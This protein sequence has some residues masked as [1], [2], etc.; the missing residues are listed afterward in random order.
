M[1]GQEREALNLIEVYGRIQA[2]A[3]DIRHDEET[4][5]DLMDIADQLRA[6]WIAQQAARAAQPAAD[7]MDAEHWVELWRLR[8][9]VKGPD[10]FETWQDAAT[11]ERIRRVRAE[12]ALKLAAQPAAEPVAQAFFTQDGGFA[13]ES[14]EDRTLKALM[15]NTGSR[16][17]V[18]VGCI[19]LCAAPQ[20]AAPAVPMGFAL[21]PLRTTFEMEEV[22]QQEDWTWADLLAAAE[23]ITEADHAMLSA[24]PQASSQEGGNT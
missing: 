5:V 23:A 16:I 12:S 24:A 22:M 7:P 10:G 13:F 8:A 18:H 1:S 6:E 17:G 3:A 2:I 11:S 15:N 21:V 4:V 19:D 20:P 9:A 14:I